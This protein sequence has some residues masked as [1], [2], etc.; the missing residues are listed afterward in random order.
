MDDALESWDK[1]TYY[2]YKPLVEEVNHEILHIQTEL[3]ED[4]ARDGLM[5]LQPGISPTLSVS[6]EAPSSILQPPN[7]FIEPRRP[8][9]WDRRNFTPG[10]WERIQLS[11]SWQREMAKRRMRAAAARKEAE[12]KFAQSIAESAAESERRVA[13]ISAEESTHVAALSG[14]VDMQLKERARGSF[15]HGI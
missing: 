11:P 3:G 8:P 2:E 7:S 4:D 5:E 14:F 15:L 12:D 6:E 10:A 13:T 1:D 9:R